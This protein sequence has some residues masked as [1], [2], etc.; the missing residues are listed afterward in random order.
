V[1][2]GTALGEHVRVSAAYGTAFKAPSFNELYYPNYGNPH[3]QP[4]QANS[5]EIRLSGRLGQDPEHKRCTWAVSGH[6]T[7]VEDL[8]AHDAAINAP[9]N[10]HQA[11]IRGMEAELALP[12]GAWQLHANFTW[13]DPR[14]QSADANHGKLLPRR[15]RI[16]GELRVDRAW[17]QY[18]LGAS[19][20]T[21]G[22]RFDDL[23]NTTVLGGYALVDMQMEYRL[24]PAWRVQARLENV[25]DKSYETAAFYNQPGR[26]LYVT[27]RYQP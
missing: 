9:N 17:G 25:L 19:V 14:N 1:A 7:R 2:W 5:L 26:G 6:E 8:I 12:I 4:E 15:A 23:A 16:N 10:I 20:R 22:R 18:S 3:L 27:L 11:R 21:A 24:S 13:Q